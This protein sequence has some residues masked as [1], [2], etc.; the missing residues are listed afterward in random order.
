M[1]RL[2]LLFAT[3]TVA[4][5]GLG[6]TAVAADTTSVDVHSLARAESNVLTLLD[7]Y[8]STPAW[9]TAFETAVSAQDADVTRLQSAIGGSGRG[10]RPAGVTVPNMVNVE[11]DHAEARLQALG[12]T[13]RTVGGGIFGIVVTADWTVCSQHPRPG[14]RVAKGSSVELD[15]EKFGCS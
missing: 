11:L 5:S 4:A 14:T 13:Y 1:K 7:H 3:V 9:R 6:A 15:V 10:A 8:E 12:L 2:A